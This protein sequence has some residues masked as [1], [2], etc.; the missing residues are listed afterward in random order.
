MIRIAVC[1]DE[2]RTAGEA[3]SLLLETGKHL[4][5]P[6]DVSLYY[7]GE[8]FARALQDGERFDII[9]MD[10]ELGGLD[11]IAAG[12]L[13]RADDANDPAQLIF[14]SSHEEYHLQ[15]FDLRPSGFIKKPVAPEDFTRKLTGAIHKTIRTRQ[16]GQT[17]FLPVQLKSGELRIS[18]RD[19]HYLESSIRRITLVTREERLQY[20]GKLAEE[21]RKLPDSHFVRI[22][23]SYIVNFYSIRAISAKR[24]LL[25]TGCELPV[26]AKYSQAVRQAYLRFRG[27]LA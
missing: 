8:R 4:N 1:E 14:I 20:Y 19:I 23:Q 9:L 26:S 22:H 15:L 10:I 27:E 12:H 21:A 2:P 6:V 11:G 24:I 25:I 7:S 18:Y 16:Q 13:L 3:E 5:E 17:G